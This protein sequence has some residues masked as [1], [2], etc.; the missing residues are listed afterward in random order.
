MKRSA[1]VYQLFKRSADAQIDTL[2][3]QLV[4]SLTDS[5]VL[6][7]AGKK[8][9]VF[10]V[11]EAV[12]RKVDRFSDSTRD[13]IPAPSCPRIYVLFP[14][15]RLRHSRVAEPLGDFIVRGRYT[16]RCSLA[17]STRLDVPTAN[18]SFPLAFSYDET[19]ARSIGRFHCEQRNYVAQ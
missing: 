16:V 3:P 6:A 5:L 18:L 2:D 19:L 4:G 12:A 10:T 11:N 7:A 1:D 14:P 9:G 17:D 8:L 15:F 13:R